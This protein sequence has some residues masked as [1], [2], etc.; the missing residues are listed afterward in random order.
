MGWFFEHLDDVL[1][2]MSVFHRVDELDELPA[3][4]FLPRMVRLA[5]YDGAVRHAMR[6]AVEQ[7][8]AIPAPTPPP[9][10]QAESAPV[11]AHTTDELKALNQTREFGP[12]GVNQA[13]VFD[14]G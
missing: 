2:D 1:S 14:F 12:L 7:P 3:A 11:R 13:G 9:G 5:L 4:V 8:E 10:Q 6:R